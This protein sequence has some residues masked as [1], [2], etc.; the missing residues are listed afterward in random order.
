MTQIDFAD[1]LSTDKKVQN[2]DNK[3]KTLL[4]PIEKPEALEIYHY[5]YKVLANGAVIDYIDRFTS[6]D[7]NHVKDRYNS[8][9]NVKAI[10]LSSAKAKLL[11][12]LERE[13][14]LTKTDYSKPV[15]V[16][17][18][19]SNPPEGKEIPLFVNPKPSEENKESEETLSIKTDIS[20]NL[21]TET[22]AKQ[23]LTIQKSGAANMVSYHGVINVANS[24]DFTELVNTLKIINLD[25]YAKHFLEGYQENIA[26]YDE[27]NEDIK[28]PSEPE[29]QEE[30]KPEPEPV[31]YTEAKF[32]I[33]NEKFQDIITI[34]K[35]LNNFADG[36]ITLEWYYDEII[37]TEMESSGAV[38]IKSF[39]P[40]YLMDT[41]DL[42]E[43]IN[44]AVNIDSLTQRLKLINKTYETIVKFEYLGEEKKLLLAY[45]AKSSEVKR[46]LTLHTPEEPNTA[47]MERAESISLNTELVFRG[48]EQI[49]EL[50][51]LLIQSKPFDTTAAH[52]TFEINEDKF[53]MSS[54]N[55]GAVEQT[56]LDLDDYSD[57]DYSKIELNQEDSELIESSVYDFDY[58]GKYLISK[59]A[60][61]SSKDKIK[62]IEFISIEFGKDNPLRMKIEY[63]SGIYTMLLMAPLD[64]GEDDEEEDD[65]DD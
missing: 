18:E 14:D 44:F 7:W 12:V 56:T 9:Y 46:K 10:N 2:D 55:D 13:R 16:N 40:K 38:F 62:Q 54:I 34:I 1:L 5:V 31:V 19:L 29:P 26:I 39:I 53:T 43:E 20:K 45:N 48:S 47:L 4:Q 17:P 58:I 30:K 25:G 3:D 15:V 6:N 27:S 42:E 21:I 36:T 41:Y 23:Y 50:R 57:S 64:S 37:I 24:L 52:L 22:I 60:L 11:E 35:T 28:E 63:N 49:L 33:E 61:L 59:D 51:E 65:E 32:S 8:H